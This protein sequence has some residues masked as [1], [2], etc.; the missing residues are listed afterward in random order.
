MKCFHAIFNIILSNSV[1][2]W[3]KRE[4]ARAPSTL[5]LPPMA[6]PVGQLSLLSLLNRYIKYTDLS[7]QD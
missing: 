6:T 7:G 1:G 4:R 5:P 3:E 2:F